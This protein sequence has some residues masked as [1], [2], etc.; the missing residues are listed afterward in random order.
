M[1]K[2]VIKLITIRRAQYR[3]VNFGSDFQKYKNKS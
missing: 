1:N 2:Y 3:G